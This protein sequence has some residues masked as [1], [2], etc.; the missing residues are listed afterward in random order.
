VDIRKPVG[1]EVEF[2]VLKPGVV[3]VPNVHVYNDEAV[4]AFISHD[5]SAEWRHTPRPPGRWHATCWVPGNFLA[6]G[7]LIVSAALGTYAPFIAHAVAPDA[8]AFE[9]VDSTD[10]DTARGDYAGRLPG[11]V[12]PLLTW[13]TTIDGP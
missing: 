11:I 9:V 10:G 2:E 6:E 13:R 3:I 5:W 7:T 12:R 8:V 4:C 1:I